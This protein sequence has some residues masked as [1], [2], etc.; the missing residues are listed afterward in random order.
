MSLKIYS[1]LTRQK[2]DFVPMTPGRVNMYVC[3]PNL[4][5]P[6]HVGH[7]FSYILFDTFKRYLKFRGYTVHHVQNFTDI[8]DRIIGAAQKEGTT[9]QA[10]A[11]RYIDR[12][13]QEMDA[14]N[15]QRA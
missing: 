5:G 9:I 14:L 12:F 4:Y 3:G 6:S 2:E 11:D 10:L 7:A 15:V 13:L 1:T 8:E